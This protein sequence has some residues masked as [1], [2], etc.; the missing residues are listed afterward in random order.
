MTTKTKLARKGGTRTLGGVEPLPPTAATLAEPDVREASERFETALTR[1]READAAF[2]A[3]GSHVE[4]AAREDRRRDAEAAASDEKLPAPLEPEARKALA[5]AERLRDATGRAAH[6][7]QDAFLEAI[8]DG[9]DALIGAAREAVDAAGADA[10]R[11]ID[12]LE[13]AL[14]R[15]ATVM[16]LIGE[17]DPPDALLGREAYFQPREA[18]KLG[19]LGDLVEAL[20]ARLMDS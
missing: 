15:R 1:H 13:A 16:H 4:A 12:G 9:R 11:A 7:A 5:E 14:T 8:L 18:R 19:K 6:G 3:A 2:I 17:L 10:L 20:R